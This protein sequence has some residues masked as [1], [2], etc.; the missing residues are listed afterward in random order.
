MVV[1][2]VNGVNGALTAATGPAAGV[3]VVVLPLWALLAF[4][5]LA[6]LAVV[7]A[8][9]FTRRVVRRQFLREVDRLVQEIARLRENPGATAPPTAPDLRPLQDQVRAIA[10]CYRTA[11]ADLV[12]AKET[13][14]K[15]RDL[16]N[17]SDAEK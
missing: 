17:H 6:A 12:A 9:V 3:G 2:V 13:L 10:V 5:L 7:L 11:L 4:P 15:F 14:A 16:H 1:A 8:V